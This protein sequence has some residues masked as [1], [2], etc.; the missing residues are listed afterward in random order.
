M[1]SACQ[2]NPFTGAGAGSVSDRRDFPF[3]CMASGTCSAPSLPAVAAEGP[4]AQMSDAE[5]VLTEV[6]TPGIE[7][8]CQ[9]WPL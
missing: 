9:L 1:L 2:A 4:R 6:A 3:Q 5:T 7:T 8:D